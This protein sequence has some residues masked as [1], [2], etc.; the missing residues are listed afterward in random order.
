MKTL[1]HTLILMLF[2]LLTTGSA[3]TLQAQTLSGPA[4]VCEGECYAYTMSPSGSYIWQVTG[5]TPVFQ[6][7]NS[8]NICWGLTGTG[9]IAVTQGNVTVATLTV[10]IHPNPTPVIIPP[11]IPSCPAANGS[12]G[13]PDQGHDCLKACANQCLNYK[14]PLNPGSTYSWDAGGEISLTPTGV[15][16]V[17][18]CWGNPGNGYI[19]VIETN[20]W[21]CTDSTLICVKIIQSPVALFTVSPGTSVCKGQTLSFNNLSTGGVT[22]FWNFGDG[23]TSTMLNPT[24]VYNTAGTYTVTLTVENACKCSSTYSLTITVSNNQAL[25][26]DCISTV[27]ANDPQ[28]WVYYTTPGCGPYTWNVTGAVSWSVLSPPHQIQVLWG[29]GPA[30]TISVSAAGCGGNLCPPTTVTVPIISATVPIS[31]ANPACVDSYEIYSAP[32]F[33]GTAYTWTVTGGTIIQGQ[34][35]H[36][37]T[38][39]WSQFPTT[40]QICVNYDNC[41]LD[42]GGQACMTVPVLAPF[43]LN[44]PDEICLNDI[45]TFNAFS[46]SGTPLCNWSVTLPNNVTLPNLA[47]NTSVFSFP[48]NLGTGIYVVTATAQNASLFCNL[49]AS[50]AVQV[51]PLPPPP[52]TI[53]GP[54][55][56][57]PNGSY[58]YSTFASPAVGSFVWTATNGTVAPLSANQ[59]VVTWGPSGPYSVSVAQKDKNS[60]FC[61]SPPITLNVNALTLGTITGTAN[62]CLNGTHTYSVPAIAGEYYNWTI[63]PSNAGSIVAGAGTNSVSIQWNILGAATVS[64]GVC[65]QTASLNVTVATPTISISAP[66]TVCAGTPYNISV[67]PATYISYQWQHQNGNTYSGQTITPNIGGCFSVTITNSNG[68]TAASSICVGQNPAPVASISTLGPTVFCIPNPVSATLYALTAVGYTYQWQLN[69]ANI[70]SATGSSYNAVAP[71]TYT[72]VVTN[73]FGC[74]AASNPI[75]IQ[76]ITCPPNPCN[77]VGV[78][79]GTA[80]PTS[81][82]NVFNFTGTATNTTLSGWTFGDGNSSPLTT[83]THTYTQAGY[84]M[85]TLSGT[86]INGCPVSDSR[87]VVVVAA[88]NFN[89]AVGCNQ[90]VTFTD[91]STYIPS[92]SISGYSWN[93]GD[94]PSGVNNTSALQNP[95]HVFSSSGSFTVTLTITASTGCT[96]VRTLTVNVPASPTASITAPVQACEDT[97]VP[98]TGSGTGS[99]VGYA[100]NFGDPASGAANTSNAALTSHTFN[101]PGVYTVTL[102][103]TDVAGCTASAN[104]SITISQNNLTGTISLSPSGIICQGS[105]ATLTAPAGGTS[106]LWSN[107]A[108]TNPITVCTSGSYKVTITDANGCEY[109]PPPKTVVITP[110][111]DIDIVGDHVICAGTPLTLN[112]LPCNFANYTYNWSGGTCT[113]CCTNAVNPSWNLNLLPPGNYNFTVTVTDN[114]TG[115][116]SVAAHAVTVYPLPLAPVITSN[117]TG[118]PLCAGANVTFTVTNP[119]GGVTYVWS[120]GQTGTTITVNNI[121]AGDWYVVAIDNVTGC[122]SESNHINICEKPDICLAPE[123][124]YTRCG[125]D[126][127][128]VANIFAGYQWYFNGSPISGAIN[129][130]YV[131]NNSGVYQVLLTNA[132]GCTALSN[133]LNLT[134]VPCCATVQ[135]TVA[136]NQELPGTYSYTFNFFNQS[137]FT[138]NQVQLTATSSNNLPVTVSPAAIPTGNVP[139]N[140]NSGNFTVT[141]SGPGAAPGATICF[142]YNF[143]YVLGNGQTVFCCHSPILYCVT[144]PVNCCQCGNYDEFLAAVNQGIQ[145]IPANVCGK[146]KFVPNA[147]GVCDSV[148]WTLDGIPLYNTT[149]IDTVTHT[150]PTTPPGW[151]II[152]YTVKRYDLNGNLC[153]QHTVCREVYVSCCRCDENFYAQ[154]NLGFNYNVW[155]FTATMYPIGLLDPGCDQV[156]WSYT[157]ANQSVIMGTSQGNNG[158]TYTF[159]GPGLYKVCMTI[160]RIDAVTGQICQVTKC[161]KVYIPCIIIWHDPADPTATEWQVSQYTGEVL[162]PLDDDSSVSFADVTV[163]VIEQPANGFIVYDPINL[164]LIFYPNTGF[165]GGLETFT[166]EICLI[167]N[168]AI[169]ETITAEIVAVQNIPT[170]GLQ[171]KT[172]LGGTLNANNPLTMDNTLRQQNLLPLEPPYERPPWEMEC[173]AGYID[174]TAMPA[175]MVD[176]VAIEARYAGAPDVRAAL[177]CG[178]LHQDGT[179]G[180]ICSGFGACE[181]GVLETAQLVPGNWYYFIIRHRNHTALMTAQPVQAVDGAVID[182]RL[183]ASVAGDGSQLVSIAGTPY[184]AMIPADIYADGIHSLYD[185]N[186]YRA[187]SG[188]VNGYYDA[189][190]NLDGQVTIADF[191]LYRPNAAHIGVQL[192]RY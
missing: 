187:Q 30:G 156:T 116:S 15:N 97:G 148:T 68:C 149:G 12:A 128:C 28:P 76:L 52:L 91:L 69:A 44:G 144:L 17:S 125:P 24:H 192:I 188:A 51:I 129:N 182:F 155:N 142:Q 82:C 160:T 26:I 101:T 16:T 122:E 111:P 153:F 109:V 59:V 27:C 100:W 86:D 57:C 124:C 75:V 58:T 119:T 99:I 74:T 39:H 121:I 38:V 50:Y 78:V 178:I 7:G 94:P 56:V 185:F 127:L 10:I 135:D 41:F 90:T 49:T 31:G 118:P 54:T 6:T 175:D 105:C 180:G 95:T 177:L 84:Y 92:A 174:H 62:A 65:S 63:I 2:I 166:Y 170:M 5:G 89:F 140:T 159:P 132:C 108:V 80:T 3:A 162:N 133:P 161:R 165:N 172:L 72:V 47:T 130:I 190:C 53:T 113:S 48:F 138:I 147:L 45:G 131:A 181:N 186:L 104:H 167:A 77:V 163:N 93:F 87:P 120:N 21:G 157:T 79:M 18:I 114:T 14:A 183:A 23:N 136:C 141:L 171:F 110:G 158:F 34:G 151:H 20:Q 70:P 184:G 154:A 112:V 115:C 146:F 189:D 191:N 107:G 40:G 1:E 143:L 145:I 85:S 164:W 179:V 66:A 73:S 42:C 9:T 106:Y 37:I 96:S 169:C 103:V 98:F 126:T 152:C 25:P 35:S 71:G 168:P 36:Q 8:V 22:Y 88:A 83:V 67:T 55:T 137:G 134:L 13:V 33:G 81:Q 32:K 173:A 29:A 64:V 123:G 43:E 176:Y 117:P 4:S 46:M 11:P 60:P 102:T 139:N 19:K 150:F 61:Q